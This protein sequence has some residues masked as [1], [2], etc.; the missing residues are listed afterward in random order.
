MKTRQETARVLR[1]AAFLTLALASAGCVVSCA[2][3]NGGGGSSIAIMTWNL[4]LLFDGVEEGTEFRDF[5]EEA[6]WT[7][8]KYLG[9]LNVIARAISEMD[10]TPDIIAL[11]EVES[12]RVVEDLASALSS[13]GYNWTHFARIPGMSLGVAL[14]SR[15]PLE[16]ARA[17]SIDLDGDIA[18]RPILEA[19]VSLPRDAHLDLTKA[20]DADSYSLLLLVC[21]W[22][23]KLGGAD[24]TESTRRAAAR[25]ILRRIRELAQTNPNLPVIVLGDLNVT[26]D[27]FARSGST[28]MRSLMPDDPEAAQFAARYFGE[29]ALGAG[30]PGKYLQQ[31]FIIV[32]H[33]KPPEAMYFPEGFL[34]LYSPW[35]VEKEGGSF[36][37]RNSWETIDHFL[38]SAQLFDGLGWEFY[39]SRAL[40]VPPF[41]NA[42]GLPNAYNP[43]IGRGISDHLPLMLFL[44]T[45]Q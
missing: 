41:V 25:V 7:Q 33:R 42:D 19:R 6:G 20:H 23:S 39:D 18:P 45:R 15:F 31:D 29:S 13:R 24:Q 3:T 43:R 10:P 37:F 1:R 34:A 21:H 26:H 40:D 30:A 36:F 35:T 8:E 17:H 12:A 22:K 28:M 27:E 9:R 11:Q 44:R 38:L 5:R 4:Q 14:I 32:S 2:E 16:K